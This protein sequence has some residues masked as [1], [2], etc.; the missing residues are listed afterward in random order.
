MTRTQSHVIV[1]KSFKNLEID[2]H[3]TKGQAEERLIGREAEKQ[4]Y[5]LSTGCISQNKEQ[6]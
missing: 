3:E 2:G 6:S 1:I 4:K 5:S